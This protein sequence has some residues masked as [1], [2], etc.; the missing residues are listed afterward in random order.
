[1]Q[2]GIQPKAAPALYLF[3]GPGE[4]LTFVSRIEDP[5]TIFKFRRLRV[6]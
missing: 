3:D 6:V 5:S 1:M 4:L 2:A